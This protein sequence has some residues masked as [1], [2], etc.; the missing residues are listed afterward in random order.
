MVHAVLHIRKVSDVWTLYNNG[1]F[2]AFPGISQI[3]IEVAFRVVE[4]WYPHV[5]THEEL[6]RYTKL[7]QSAQRL[8]VGDPYEVAVNPNGKSQVALHYFTDPLLKYILFVQ[9]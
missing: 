3:T 6:L 8:A 7:E 4:F 2:V 1:Q 9:F 5:D